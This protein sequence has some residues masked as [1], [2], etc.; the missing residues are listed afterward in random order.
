MRK[1]K[2]FGEDSERLVFYVLCFANRPDLAIKFAPKNVGKGYVKKI[3]NEISQRDKK[4]E[5]FLCLKR[6]V[7]RIEGPVRSEESFNEFMRCLR[8]IIRVRD[9]Y[10]YK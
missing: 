10:L 3:C 1:P 4:V 7:T 9:S 2:Y 5:K 8:R 6:Y